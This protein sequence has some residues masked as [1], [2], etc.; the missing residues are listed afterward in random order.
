MLRVF[1]GY[2]HRQP[3]SY[4]V[5]NYSIISR[6]S[7]PVAITPLILDQLPISRGGLTP[8]TFSRFMVPWLCGYQGFGLFLDAD[9]LLQ[10][11]IAELFAMADPNKAVQIVVHE[12]AFERASVMLF[13]CEK[14]TVLTPDFVQHA[15]GLHSISWALEGEI[16]ALPPEWNHLV[17]YDESREKPKLIHYTQGVPIF[18]ETS[19]SEHAEAWMNDAKAMN[20]AR[21]WVELM[22]NS[23]HAVQLEDGRKVP[24]LTFGEKAIAEAL[25]KRGQNA[26]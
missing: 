26:T 21:P 23:V 6:S 17:G 20:S 2:D 15:K 8:F 4:Q 7:K 3:I 9:M 22:G 12:K 1:I 18:P 13:N 16:G 11:D 5:L 14:C 10:A 24:R 19:G 25:A